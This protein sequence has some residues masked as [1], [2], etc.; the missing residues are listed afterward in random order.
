MGL[1]L[2]SA[3]E[4]QGNETLVDVYQDKQSGKYGWAITHNKEKYCRPIVSCDPVYNSKNKALTEGKKLMK[5]IKES[6]LN[7]QKK[8]LMNIIGGTETAETIDS[9]VQTSKIEP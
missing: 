1:S 8:S 6:D 9:I 4:I 3:L 7:S 2:L 5:Q